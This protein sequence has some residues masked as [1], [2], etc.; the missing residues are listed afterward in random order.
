MDQALYDLLL[1]S[2]DRVLSDEEHKT[3]NEGLATSKE[4]REEKEW[5]Q[6]MRVLITEQSYEFA[7][8]FAGRVMHKIEALSQKHI[9][10]GLSQWLLQMFPKVAVSGIA[11]I[12]LLIASSYF[13]EGSFSLDTLLGVSE[14]VAEDAEYYLIENF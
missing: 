13:M 6:R 2:F 14:V 10:R 7:P 12:V 8:F 9:E 1:A 11:I 4:L 3:L 5:L